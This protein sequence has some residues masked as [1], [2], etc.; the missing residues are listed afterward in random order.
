MRTDRPGIYRAY[1]R[2]SL[3]GLEIEDRLSADS[4]RELNCCYS[5]NSLI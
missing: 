4:I 5:T 2:E 3:L 1:L